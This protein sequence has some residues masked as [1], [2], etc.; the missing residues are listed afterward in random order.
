M[1]LTH[2]SFFFSAIIFHDINTQ[3]VYLLPCLW[4]FLLFTN[5]A[6]K[7]KAAIDIDMHDIQC[8]CIF[9]LLFEY[10][11]RKRTARV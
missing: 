6:I 10:I 3:F 1:R 7:N 8:L 9:I 4:T 11:P 2:I 5:V